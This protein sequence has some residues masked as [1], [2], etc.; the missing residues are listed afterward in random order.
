MLVLASAS[1]RRRELLAAAGIPF[2]VV[3]VDLDETP[4]D[5]EVPDA[6]V[7]RL[8]REKAS[9]AQAMRPD[10]LVLGADTI[11]VVSGQILGKPRDAEDAA[12]MLRALAGRAHDVLTGVALTGARGTTVELERTRVWFTPLSEQEIADY[13]ASGEPR[14]KAGA[15]AIQ[16]LASKFVVRID[17]SYTNVVGLPVAL[18]YRLLKGYS[19]P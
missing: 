19:E 13:G 15:Y 4:L 16:G 10:A 1:P 7:Q 6:H 2:E 12:R 8:A 18:V 5:G 3:P 9:T 14:D 11:V 17:G